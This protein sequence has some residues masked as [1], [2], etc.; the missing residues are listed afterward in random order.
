VRLHLVV[1][2]LHPLPQRLQP[3]ELDGDLRIG[4]EPAALAHEQ[5]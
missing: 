2:D 5:A 4:Q 1:D 3:R